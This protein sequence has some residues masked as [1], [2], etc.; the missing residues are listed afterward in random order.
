MFYGSFAFAEGVAHGRP[1]TCE[2]AR[3]FGFFAVNTTENYE[4][5][6]RRW[7]SDDRFARGCV[8]AKHARGFQQVLMAQGSQD[9]LSLFILASEVEMSQK[10]LW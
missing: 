6:V 2:L 5:T 1:N 3:F 8:L 4:F 9:T 7:E 10:L